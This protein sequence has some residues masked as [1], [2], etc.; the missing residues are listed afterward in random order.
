MHIPFPNSFNVE[1]EDRLG[2]GFCQIFSKVMLSLNVKEKVRNFW[3]DTDV[4]FCS[5]VFFY[6]IQIFFPYPE[7]LLCVQ[8]RIRPS[9]DCLF[10]LKVLITVI[11]LI[12]EPGYIF[13]NGS[14][15]FEVHTSAALRRNRNLM[16]AM[17]SP[18]KGIKT[19][20]NN[21]FLLPCLDFHKIFK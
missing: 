5:F 7:F 16:A 1:T 17:A 9:L 19:T 2:F 4:F 21:M 8:I 15:Y 12:Q 18:E 20:E 14:V 3:L 6:W 10:F 11:F 13:T